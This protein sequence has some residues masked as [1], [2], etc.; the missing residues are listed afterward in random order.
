M[1]APVHL[2]GLPDGVDRDAVVAQMIR[3]ASSTGFNAWWQRVEAVGFCANPIHL[4]GLDKF[5]RDHQAFT[6]CNNRRAVVCPSCSDLYSRDTWQLIHA[7]LRGGHHDIPSTVAD[8]PQVFVTLTAPSFGAVHTVR[9]TGNCHP[10]NAGG[11]ECQ[12]GKSLW[13]DRLH[14]DTDAELGQPLCRDCYDYIRHVLFTWHAPELWRRFTIRLHR[15]LKRELCRRAEQ[16][17]HTRISFMKVVELQRRA[18]PHFHAVIRLDAASEPGQPPATPDTTVS[19][20]QFVVL[21]QQA[22][23]ET[24]LALPGDR[25]LRFGEQIDVKVIASANR[26]EGNEG[27]MSGRQIAGYL[28]KYVT[29]SVADFGIGVRRFSPAAIDQL[30]VADHVRE[31]LRAIVAISAEESY[32]DMLYWVHTLGYRGHVVSKS[33]QFSTTMTALR[34]RRADWQKSRIDDAR[35]AVVDSSTFEPIPW[36]VQRIGHANFGDRVLAVSASGRAQEQR[37]A[38][39][40][41]EIEGA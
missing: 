23:I 25:T 7:G 16:S 12:H 17:E 14:R 39:L 35:P 22:A 28:A 6:R 8:H 36:Q 1:N 30:E 41:A 40:Q 32:A 13:C 10:R 24:S 11:R 4:A 29:K 21:V 3:R 9:A 20:K 31:I 33:R 18:L 26:K 37:I 38:A 27:Q 2:P 19:A 34:E 5:G 15:G